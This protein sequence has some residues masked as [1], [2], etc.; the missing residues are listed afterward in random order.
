[1]AAESVVTIH[2]SSLHLKRSHRKIQRKIANFVSVKFR[3]SWALWKRRQAPW[4]GN[5]Q[6][7]LR[8]E[9]V[10]SR[11]NI[12]QSWSKWNVQQIVPYRRFSRVFR[13][14]RDFPSDGVRWEDEDMWRS[15]K[16]IF[17]HPILS[18]RKRK[19]RQILTISE[20]SSTALHSFRAL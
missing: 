18:K 10:S 2:F 6:E 11:K 13:E 4:L 15:V 3:H 5:F 19:R 16:F 1:M 9:F 14:Y 7:I 20:S 17:N 12:S 8:N